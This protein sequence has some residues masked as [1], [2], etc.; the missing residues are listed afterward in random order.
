MSASM[1]TSVP[2]STFM[3]SGARIGVWGRWS[4]RGFAGGDPGVSCQF[5]YLK[6]IQVVDLR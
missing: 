2:S 4:R 3:A 1:S 6:I 5:F